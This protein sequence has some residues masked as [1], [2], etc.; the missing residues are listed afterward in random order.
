MVWD[1]K[2]QEEPSARLQTSPRLPPGQPQ[3]GGQLSSV[4]L[5]AETRSPAHCEYTGRSELHNRGPVLSLWD[6]SGSKL[7]SCLVFWPSLSCCCGRYKSCSVPN[8]E[9]YQTGLGQN[10]KLPLQKTTIN[11]FQKTSALKTMEF[12]FADKSNFLTPP[13]FKIW[14]KWFFGVILLYAIPIILTFI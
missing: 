8:G 10:A 4:L 9:V 3:L 11:L 7:Y 5:G 1:P 6:G 12:W 14:Q 2:G 13:L